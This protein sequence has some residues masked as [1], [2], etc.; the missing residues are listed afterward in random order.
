MPGLPFRVAV[1]EEEVEIT[2]V[3]A[4]GAGGQNVNKVSNAI[5]LRFA[6]AASSLPDEL[7]RRLLLWRDQRISGDGVVIIKAQAHRSL[8]RNRDDALCRLRELIARAAAVAP[9]RLPTRPTSSS[10]KRRLDGKRQRGAVKLLRAR[11]NDDQ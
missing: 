7:K 4:Q 3:R 10:Q 1:R 8:E 9:P 6:I 2:A 5:H 11:V